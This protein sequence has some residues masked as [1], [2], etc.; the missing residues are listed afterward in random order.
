M[1]YYIRVLGNNLGDIPLGKLRE[2]SHLCN[3]RFSSVL[4]K[5]NK[6]LEIRGHTLATILLGQR[7]T[8]VTSP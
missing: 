3:L 1:G 8:D 6:A 2:A 4:E 5:S 7:Q